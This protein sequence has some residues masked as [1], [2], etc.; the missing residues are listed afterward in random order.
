MKTPQMSAIGKGPRV[1]QLQQRVAVERG[2]VAAID[3]ASRIALVAQYSAGPAQTRSLSRYLFELDA[4]GFLP[5]VISVTPGQAPLAFGHGIPDS[6]IVLRRDNVGYDFGSWATALGLFPQIKTKETVLITNDSMLGPFDSLAPI[7]DWAAEPSGPD[8]R[9]LTS[10]NQLTY[11]L[12]SFFL[13][14]RG[15]ILADR[16]WTDFFNGIRVLPS[17]DDVVQRY[18]VGV[19]QL[20]F[21]EGYSS[22]ELVSAAELGVPFGNPTIDGWR[23][24]IEKG[25]PFLKRTVMTHPSTELEAAEAKS[26]VLKHFRQNILEW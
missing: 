23:R 2:S 22:Q 14:F 12:Q 25:V 16:P 7:L 21:K 3:T 4:A 8:L 18:E 11:H 10:S 19:Y 9:S 1:S 17:K 6:A 15:G 13:A 20:A 24:L 5:I 26:Y